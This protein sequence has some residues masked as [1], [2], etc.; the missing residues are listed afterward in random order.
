VSGKVEQLYPCMFCDDLL[1]REDY[2][3]RALKDIAE[4]KAFKEKLKK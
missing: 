3:K 4:I 1:K 2:F